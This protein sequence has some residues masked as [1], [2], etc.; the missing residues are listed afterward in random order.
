[1]YRT[2]RW[3]NSTCD[4]DAS[5]GKGRCFLVYK[6]KANVTT[7]TCAEA[8]GSGSR[9]RNWELTPLQLWKCHPGTRPVTTKL[10]RQGHSLPV[11]YRSS[12]PSTIW[13]SDSVKPFW[14]PNTGVTVMMFAYPVSVYKAPSHMLLFSSQQFC[15]LDSKCKF[16]LTYKYLQAECQKDLKNRL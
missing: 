1:M 7:L 11:L 8:S 6:S 5:P 4:L 16:C 12:L 9:A 15:K 10:A 14:T 2:G 3:I 13:A